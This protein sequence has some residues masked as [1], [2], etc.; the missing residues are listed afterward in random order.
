[1]LDILNLDSL[2]ARARERL[3]PM[4]FD[5]IAGGAADEWTLRENREAWSR[6]QLLPRM[7]RGVS[8]RSLGTTVLGTAVSMPVLVPPMGFHGLCHDDAEEATAAAAAAEQTIFCA[9]TVSNC[10][11][12]AIA[13]ASDGPRWFQLYVYRDKAI[14]RSLVERAAAAGYS[15]LCL[16]V[17]TPMAGPRE[18]DRRN[19]LRMPGHLELGNFSAEHTAMH[20][21]GG[22]EGSSL[23]AYIASQW[24]PGLTWDDV[25][26]LRSIAPMP[27]VV[28]GILAPAD[29]AL[30]IEHGAAAVIVSN[31]G[32]RQLDSVPAP[33][34]V[35]E[36][37]VEAVGGR[38][39]VLLDGGV[40]RGTDVLKALAFGARAVL[41]GRPVLWGLTLGGYD[42]VR[43]VL[44]HIRAET[45]LAMAL[46]GCAKI[47]DVT[48]EL[49]A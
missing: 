28:K 20:H 45:D 5:Y 43:A 16:T 12:E 47:T 26:W 15:A 4:L 11:L 7:L 2:E 40:R 44:Q 25:A 21:H 34:S 27:V 10:S 39:D 8:A 35:L 29:A 3:D 1:M 49:I 41:V 42:G 30:A 23:A 14:T 33:I 18:R 32:G 48:R 24:D 38:G 36:R 6:Y 37:V 31:H 13:K 17:D 46:A 9:S 22:G 19:N